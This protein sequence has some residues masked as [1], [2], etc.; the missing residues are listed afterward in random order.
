MS[1]AYTTPEELFAEQEAILARIARCQDLLG[2]AI[3]RAR[4]ALGIEP[5]ARSFFHDQVSWAKRGA[6]PA[7]A[8]A[9]KPAPVELAPPV[10]L[11]VAPP[12]VTIP[13][14]VTVAPPPP[15]VAPPQVGDAPEV[16]AG[17]TAGTFFRQQV[18]WTGA[19]AARSAPSPSSSRPSLLDQLVMGQETPAL[20][21]PAPPIQV[22][23]PAPPPIDYTMAAGAFFRTVPWQAGESAAFG[24]RSG[25]GNFLAAATESA[26]RAAQRLSTKPAP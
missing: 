11:P 14:P 3:L 18:A 23:R 13:P 1:E 20:P 16:L 25:G 5:T 22:M 19:A 15:P 17:F 21:T 6:A 26:L 12:P 2:S 9:P 4:V 24:N 8:R 10:S 7:P